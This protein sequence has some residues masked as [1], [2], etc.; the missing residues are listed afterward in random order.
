MVRIDSRLTCGLTGDDVAKIA[1]AIG[2]KPRWNASRCEHGKTRLQ[3]C[4]SCQGGYVDD[5]HPFA[6]IGNACVAAETCDGFDVCWIHERHRDAALAEIKRHND[7]VRS[8]L[9]PPLAKKK[10]D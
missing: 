9:L 7:L 5:T 10:E 3:A 1:K 8:F 4:V 6:N 2:V